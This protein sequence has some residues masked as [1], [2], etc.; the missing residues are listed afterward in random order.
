MAFKYLSK[1]LIINGDF[2]GKMPV[3][4]TRKKRKEIERIC[5]E[6]DEHMKNPEYVKAVYEFIRATSR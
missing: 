5:K 1:Q 4:K 2:V 6:I 3:T